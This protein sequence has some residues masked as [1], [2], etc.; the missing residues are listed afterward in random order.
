M[1][2]A[3]AATSQNRLITSIPPGTEIALSSAEHWRYLMQRQ[4]LVSI[5]QHLER[6]KGCITDYHTLQATVTQ[7]ELKVTDLESAL[8]YVDTAKVALEEVA[9][10]EVA[11]KFSQKIRNWFKD[12]WKDLIAFVLGVIAAAEAAFI[13]YQTVK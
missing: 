6:A 5:G 3:L 13:I 2:T 12:K 9:K 4:T 7:L 10:I 8:N 11:L 1:A